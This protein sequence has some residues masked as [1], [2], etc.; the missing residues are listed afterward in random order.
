VRIAAGAAERVVE[1]LLAGEEIGTRMVA[2]EA[3]AA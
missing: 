3:P 1:R 2:G